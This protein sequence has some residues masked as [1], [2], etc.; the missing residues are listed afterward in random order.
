MTG[1]SAGDLRRAESGHVAEHKDYLESDKYDDWHRPSPLH[2]KLSPTLQATITGRQ[3]CGCSALHFQAV[4]TND[5]L[6]LISVLRFWK[7]GVQYA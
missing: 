1:Y 4:S 7:W 6:A 3:I 5:Y 2:M